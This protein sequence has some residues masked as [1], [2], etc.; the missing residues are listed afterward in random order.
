[1]RVR[2]IVAVVLL[3]FAFIILYFLPP[4][5]LACALSV[6]CAM[7]VYE[8]IHA[9][10][11]IKGNARL[12][13]YTMLSAV[14]IPV[15]AYFDIIPVIMP[16]ALLI[17]L[18][19]VFIESIAR[20]KTERQLPFVHMLVILF[21]GLAIPY[22]LSTLVSLRLMDGG[23]LLVFLPVM[24]AF[25]T[26]GGAYFTGVLIGK[27]KAFPLVSP[28]KTVEGYIGGIF[29]G[30]SAMIFCGV[31]IENFTAYTSVNYWALLAYGVV[32]AVMTGLGDLAF[33]LVKRELDL[34]DFGRLLP[35]HGGALDRFDS[36]IFTV[37]TFYL[38]AMALPVV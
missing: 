26:D 6:I 29:F 12:C 24:S 27:R 10:V 20:F 21:G 23:N 5:V 18:S 16:A 14:A 13:L 35:G 32:G 38:L 37:P 1:M 25:I 34:K 19:L 28:K 8:L 22:L 36:L 7:A 33:S 2:I 11:G 3:P 31:Y 30:I 15:G 4:Y 17:L 9:I